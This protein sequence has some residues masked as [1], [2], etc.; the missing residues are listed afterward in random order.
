LAPIP[1][2]RTPFP[3][4]ETA[5]F[6]MFF[7]IQPGGAYLSTP[8]PI[9]GAWL[10]Y[11]NNSSWPVGARVRFFNYDPDDKGWF[12]YGLGTV[13]ATAVRPDPTTRLYGFTGASFDNGVP[14]PPGG[15]TPGGGTS[16]DPVDP[17]TGAFI[18]TKT[19]LYLPDVMPI[20]L[21]RTYNAQDPYPRAF[22][23]GMTH[24]YG[25]IQH[26]ANWPA[27][28]DI[29]AP[30]GGKLHFDRISGQEYADSIWAHTTTPTPFYQSR[31]TFWGNLPS[32]HGWQ[33]TQKDGTVYVFNSGAML[34][35]IRD[36]YG[37]ETRLTWSF[38]PTLLQRVTS[39]N[40]RWIAFTYGAG[41][42]VS[43]VTDNIGRTV[44]YT[45]DASG[46]LS[47]VTDPEN[48]VTTYTWD[49][50][51]RIATVKDGRNIVYLTNHYDSCGRVDQQTLADPA[52]GY[53]FA[54]TPTS[55][56]PITQTDI[57]DPGTHVNRQTYQNH[58]LVTN[59]EAQ[60]TTEERTTNYDR[61][62]G[63][64]LVTAV[65][66]N[67]V[68]VE[69]AGR[70][71]EFT[72][73]DYGH[74]LTAK[75][76]AGTSSPV[77]TTYTYEPTYFQLATVTD[78]LSHTWTRTYDAAAKPNG[79][80][81]PLGHH[82]TIGLNGQ[83]QVTDITDPL[84]HHWQLGYTG[85]DLTSRTNP[86]GATWTQFVDAGGR[87]LSSTD[88]LG[89]VTRTTVDKLNRVTAV[90]DP[91]GGQTQ[92]SY[93]PNS[94]V[95]SLTD[96]LTHGTSYT[97]D[98]SDRVATRTDPLQKAASYAYDFNGN[99]SQL[100]DRK[101]QVTGYQY[102]ARDRLTRVT[103]QDT[104]TIN[105]TYDPADHLTQITDSANGTT[106]ITRA[107]DGLDHLTSETTP[108]G[109]IDYTYDT[110][111][112]RATMTVQGQPA[113]SYAYDNANRLTSITQGSNVVSF[114]YDD[115]DRRST[116]TFPNG[117]VGTYGYD[118]ANQ[119]TSLAY[120]LNNNPVGDLTYTYDLAGNRMSVGG[121]WA[122]T[123]LPQALAS[124][125][126]DA[127]NRIQT[128]NGTTYSYDANGNLGSDG[129]TSYLWNARNQLGGLSGASS[130]NFTYDGAGRRQSKSIG[131]TTSFLYDGANTVQEL[132]GTTPTANLLTG[133]GI[134]QTLT[135]TD[136][137]GTNTLLTDA[138]GSTLELADPSG[139]SQRHYAYEPFGATSASGNSST[140]AA[141]F[142]GRDNDGTGLYYYRARF[143]SPALQRFVS[144]DPAGFGAGDPN[145]YA[146]TFDAPTRWRDPTGRFVMI[147]LVLCAAGAGGSMAA[148]WM[149]GRKIDAV[150]A[151]AWCAA[152][153]GLGFAGPAI[154]AAMG[155]GSAA[156]YGAAAAGSTTG[157]TVLGHYPGY[158]QMARELGANVF[159]VPP[160]QWSWEANQAFL[161]DVIARGDIV[162]LSTSIDAIRAGSTL[163][164]E[165]EYLMSRGYQVA[166]DGVTLFK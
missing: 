87:V 120:T 78:P 126:Y 149:G 140:N 14:T 102:D 109:R 64:Q 99:L 38:F 119:L 70:R 16:G 130:A 121:S 157:V 116:I 11:P 19:D 139:S 129:L 10:V 61:Q 24:A 93:D 122:R 13:T 106:T 52:A 40:G 92:F 164:Q 17:S 145:L 22:G 80:T 45:Y 76:L 144:E 83:G 90:T 44:T 66:E 158:L 49:T 132:S 86:L 43:Q 113:V 26:S 42:R 82:T 115:S 128:W 3:L 27:E 84:T 58:Y 34:D 59:V 2:D 89:R 67:S 71:T 111:N 137:G 103:F 25:F 36:R 161:D 47:T 81:D 79:T 95:L 5:T 153:L 53:T 118:N 51:N 23:I 56:G 127:G 114:T 57:T 108:Q 20:A 28:V 125:T 46:R 55:C 12:P 151:A 131:S 101:G 135:R 88:P 154:G 110:A 97:Y 1:L 146:Y 104:S 85:G 94:R 54:Y 147:P 142:T 91:L 68:L 41:N 15:G 30:D 155:F 60:G 62:A 117:I 50:S 32:V 4:P 162:K 96:A 6:T 75:Q 163:A 9:K 33:V 72:Y 74:V 112:R 18:L 134:D 31:M 107:Y 8:G 73:D 63:S 124:A 123:G 143:F 39:P 65:V 156:A 150:K 136:A 165:V 21:T 48:N 133:L 100:T 148:D 69:G 166:A 105:Y 160:E 7:T 35:A 152:G 77:T 29:Y 37:N 141:Q 138:L 159:D 98:T